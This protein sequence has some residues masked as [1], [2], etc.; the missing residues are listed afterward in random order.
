M[1]A[2]TPPTLIFHFE[3]PW[4]KTLLYQFFYLQLTSTSHFSRQVNERLCPLTFLSLTFML[5]VLSVLLCYQYSC[6]CI[7][8]GMNLCALCILFAFLFVRINLPLYIFYFMLNF[9]SSKL[10]ILNSGQTALILPH[11][12]GL[13]I[14]E[15][16]CN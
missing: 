11:T 15:R 7:S 9:V 8:L 4:N 3:Y 16:Q 10:F 14:T 6:L 1:T 5:P 13:A 12:N 2:N